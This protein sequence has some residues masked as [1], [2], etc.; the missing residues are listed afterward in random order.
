MAALR[1]GDTKVAEAGLNNH[2]R[3]GDFVPFDRN[4]EPG[5]GRSPAPH[6]DQQIG[7]VLLIEQTIEAGDRVSHF[8]AAAALEVLRI[9]YDD[10]AKIV[11]AAIA[12][13]LAALADQLLGPH[14]VQC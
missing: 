4:A 12:Q 7:P 6:P 1:W 5:F 8:L 9:D 10:I 13:N 11:D 14:I 3:A 2:A